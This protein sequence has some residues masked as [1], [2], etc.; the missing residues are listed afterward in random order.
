MK[1]NAKIQYTLNGE[2]GSIEFEG[3]QKDYDI[4]ITSMRRLNGCEI[5][6]TSARAGYE[7]N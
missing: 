2:I 4:L 5:L 7:L 6:R 1:T 3:C